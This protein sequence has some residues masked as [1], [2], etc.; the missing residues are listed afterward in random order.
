MVPK[1]SIV[2]AAYNVEKYIERCLNSLINQ[3]LREIE[4]I[5]VNDGSTDDTQQICESFQGL[6]K[7]L[8]VISQDNR[9]LSEARNTG[10]RIAK[11]SYIAFV[12]ADDSMDRTMYK[13]LYEEMKNNNAEL[14]ICNFL[15]VWEDNNLKTIKSRDVLL[16]KSLLK[17]NILTK[18]LTRH[19][20][21]LV[22]AWNKLYKLD[23]I[24][25][26]NIMFLNKAFFEDVGFMV[27]Y[28]INVKKICYVN[29]PLYRYSQRFGSITKSYNPI[30]EESLKST[31]N[32]V[33]NIK[34]TMSQKYL[35]TFR[36]RLLIYTFNYLL[37][38]G[39]T[40]KSIKDQIVSLKKYS[41]LLPL[42]HRISFL[43]IRFGIYNYL[44]M[45]LYRR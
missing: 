39:I 17:G 43:L 14:V 1:V 19:D 9:G 23:V 34:Q 6:D 8:V 20:E 12:D 40:K 35:Q 15:K 24:K 44:Y 42:K 37:R 27:R 31:V 36:L 7:R 22:V 5:V 18:F 38:N 21:S 33:N 28:L 41:K 10:I 4:I 11:A 26:N 13:K 29:E 25:N 45:K 16:N 2:V 32:I 3:T 30:I